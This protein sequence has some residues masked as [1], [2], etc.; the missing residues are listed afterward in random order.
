LNYKEIYYNKRLNYDY[1]LTDFNPENLHD[2]FSL[3]S[4]YD[5]EK[6]REEDKNELY[7]MI[8]NEFKQNKID[9]N[10]IATFIINYLNDYYNNIDNKGY[11]LYE[12]SKNIDFSCPFFNELSNTE[13]FNK[14][15]NII[16]TEDNFKDKDNNLKNIYKS[17]FEYLNKNNINYPSI[18]FYVGENKDVNIL[19]EFNINF[20]KLKKLKLLKGKDYSNFDNINFIGI[21]NSF[22]ILDNLVYFEFDLSTYDTKDPAKSEIIN[23]FKSLKYLILNNSRF[24]SKFELKL[25]KLK[26]LFY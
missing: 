11:S 12:F 4:F 19:K 13:F 6:E 22:D 20:K 24:S 17:K 14:I 1:F 18:V 8:E 26:Y 10:V 3:L 25:N 15:F 7:K 9:H 2:S 5:R 23:N 21:I 16:I